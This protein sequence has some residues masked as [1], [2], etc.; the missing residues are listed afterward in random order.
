MT[1]DRYN[2]ELSIGDIVLFVDEKPY[3]SSAVWAIKGNIVTLSHNNRIY[4]V[5]SCNTVRLNR[6]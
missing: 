2:R 6:S 4:N 3:W 1:K 5:G